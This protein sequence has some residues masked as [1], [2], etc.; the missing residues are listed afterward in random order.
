MESKKWSEMTPEEKKNAKVGCSVIF[1]IF[2]MIMI[3]VS[4]CNDSSS[5]KE[6]TGIYNSEWDG[7]VYEVKKYLMDNL[8]DP[9]SYKPVEWSPVY[10]NP[11]TLLYYVRHKYRAKNAF[12]GTILKEQVFMLDSL[13][14]ILSI[15]DIKK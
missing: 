3:A 4:Q 14:N 2:I 11:N 1:F 13:G 15:E 6:R 8:N 7:S 5:E 10:R 9:D 12:G